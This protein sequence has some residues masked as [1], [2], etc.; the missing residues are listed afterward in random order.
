VHDNFYSVKAVFAKSR[1]IVQRG[2]IKVLAWSLE[3]RDGALELRIAK[4]NTLTR[5]VSGEQPL[6]PLEHNS[7][8]RNALHKLR[9]KALTKT[10]SGSCG[11]RKL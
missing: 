8:V 5:A 4:A 1:R 6:T 7:H 2:V 11:V 10:A 3:E 9:Y